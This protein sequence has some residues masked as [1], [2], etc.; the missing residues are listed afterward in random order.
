MAHARRK[1]FDVH[2]ATKSPLAREALER[3]AA[4][5]RI[6]DSDPR[7]SARSAPAR[8]D[9]ADR[10]ADGPSCRPGWRRPA[11]DLRTSEL[12][13]AIRYTL[14]R[15]EALTLVLRDGRACIDNPPPN[16]PCARLPSA[17]ATG[18]SPDP[19]KARLAAHQTMS[20]QI[21]RILERTLR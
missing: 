9:R 4:L 21:K 2:E 10:A 1:F 6:E 20:L 7:P 15:W 14:S 19:T 11:R 13:G 18:P 17:A 5:Y 3:I 16:V 12:A 8:P